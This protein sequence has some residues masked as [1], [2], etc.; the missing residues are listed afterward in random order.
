VDAKNLSISITKGEIKLQNVEVKASAFD[1]LH[2]PITIKSGTVGRFSLIV[3]HSI[4]LS[5]F[6]H[7]HAV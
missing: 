4:M 6:S 1:E 5:G 2:M 7:S 3:L